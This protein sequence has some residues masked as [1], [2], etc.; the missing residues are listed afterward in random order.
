MAECGKF[1][2]LILWVE[3]LAS[4]KYVLLRAS[5]ILTIIKKGIYGILAFIDY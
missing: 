1:N 4:A 2:N 3:Y 5:K